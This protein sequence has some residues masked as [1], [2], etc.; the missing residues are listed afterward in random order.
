LF[1]LQGILLVTATTY[2]YVIWMC[3][4]CGKWW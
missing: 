4:V 3:S 1:V 2:P